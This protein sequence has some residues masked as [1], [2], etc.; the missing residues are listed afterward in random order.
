MKEGFGFPYSVRASPFDLTNFVMLWR[1][2]CTN[3]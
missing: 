2:E 1:I 3:N